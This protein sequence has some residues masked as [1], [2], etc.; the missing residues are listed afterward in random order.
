MENKRAFTDD[1]YD[2]AIAIKQREE[3]RLIDR[4]QAFWKKR[5]MNPEYLSSF[6]VYCILFNF[7][8][9]NFARADWYQ[10]SRLIRSHL[11][12]KDSISRDEL[13][14]ILL[15]VIDLMKMVD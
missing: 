2:L 6:D 7:A 12:E 4:F 1:G 14:D 3:P 13:S 5:C 8:Y 15:T 11:T 9:E 10:Y